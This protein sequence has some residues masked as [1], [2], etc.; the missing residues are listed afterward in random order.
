MSSGVRLAVPAKL[1]PGKSENDGALQAWE[2]AQMRLAAELVVLSACETGLG[3]QVPGEGLV[4]LT[5][6]LQLAGARSV[7]ASQWAVADRSTRVLMA[8]FHRGLRAGLSKDEALRQAM[9]VV[10]KEEGRE[11][12]YHWAAFLLV[13]DPENRRLAAPGATPAAARTAPG[14]RR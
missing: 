11:R 8:A 6:A 4:G 14:R 1:D 5:R 9:G 10:A 13:G 3:E 12:P 7:V 2:V